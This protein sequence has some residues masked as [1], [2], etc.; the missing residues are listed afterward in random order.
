MRN[1][2]PFNTGWVFHEGDDRS[3]HSRLKSGKNVELPHNAV[4]LPYGYLDETS[5]QR[6]FTYQKSLQWRPDFEERQVSL[7]F[8]GAMADSTVFLNGKEIYAHPD[9]YTPFEV[10]LTDHIHRGENLLCVRIDGSENPGIPP[11]GGQIDYLAYAGI[12]RDAWL[13][14][15]SP[16]SIERIRV[17][18]R[19]LPDSGFSASVRCDIRNGEQAEEPVAL[20]ASLRSPDGTVIS[21]CRADAT[22]RDDSVTLSFGNL[23]EI[24]RWD[25]RTP[26]L[27]SVDVR[28]ECMG[29]HDQVT[30]RFGFRTAEFRPEGFFLNG[31]KV[32]LRGLNRHQSFPY[33]GYAAGRRAQERDAE[34]LKNALRCN[35]VRTSHY[36]QS[37]WFLDHCNRIGLLVFEE[38]PGWQHIGGSD[39]KR[40]SLDNLR[41]MIRRD[42]NHPSIV[43]WGTRINESPDDH[44][45][46]V[47]SND[48][49]HT[50]DPSRQ[51]GG[52]RKI[53]HSE[54]L[55]DVYTMN[56]FV[57]GSEGSPAA[58]PPGSNRRRTALRRPRD[59]TGLDR[60][61][62]YLV[63]EFNGHMFPT[64]RT[65]PEER[66]IEHVQRHLEVLDAA[67]G[68]AEI[69]GCVG[70]CM[71]DYNTHKD[72]GSGER[73]C[74]HGVLDMFRE[75]K[76]A[77][78]AYASQGDP[79]AGVVMKPVT[80]WANGERSIGGSIPLV[81]L[82]NCDAVEFRFAD[83]PE[84]TALPDRSRF[85]NLPHPPV[86]ID[87]R[88]VSQGELEC[89]GKAWYDLFLTG[90]LDGKPV[91]H[92]HLVANP[93]PT[94][95]EVTPDSDELLASEKDQ[96]RVVVRALDQAG[97]VLVHFN[98]PLSI[99]IS[100]PARLVGP[101][102]VPFRG[103][104]AVFWLESTGETGTVLAETRTLELGRSE[105]RLRAARGPE[106][107]DRS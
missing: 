53:T 33:I 26:V 85:P 7:V 35:L 84:K 79:D 20:T 55:E 70:W 88:H 57:L 63:T 105:V 87:H 82:T 67:Y 78:F 73:I 16:V 98:E 80:F 15:T 107:G 5:F 36:P 23:R 99:R 8:D 10:G 81:V 25:L 51:T 77:A 68:S 50:L 72:F 18:T 60:D 29:R 97:N 76:P 61:V 17:E 4:D 74:H 6:P 40:R 56:D 66:Q 52:V 49:A 71:A 30:T 34:L 3:L 39:W 58:P 31:R 13:K 90:V 14:C 104:S 11:F 93:L 96:V 12:Y 43:L 37:P 42:W 69:S 24:S 91:R 64:K 48:L 103:G 101:G 100:G 102:I 19:E 92:L 22:T 46:Y 95:L 89:W 54:F 27:Y 41:S 2:V 1:V 75:P 65:D 94:R 106:R 47:R 38:I 45:F 83:G 59:V 44:D 62:P 9:G 86:I 32:T 28:L 21:Q